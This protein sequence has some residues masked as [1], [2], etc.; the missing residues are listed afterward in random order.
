MVLVEAERAVRLDGNL[1]I[2][3]ALAVQ[4]LLTEQVLDDNVALAA[5][6][7]LY[8]IYLMFACSCNHNSVRLSCRGQYRMIEAAVLPLPLARVLINS[9][10]SGCNP[11]YKTRFP[12]RQRIYNAVTPY[13]GKPIRTLN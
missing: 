9:Y 7:L 1:C 2:Q 13:T 11:N 6:H 12:I 3:A 4:L 10:Y 8:L 5:S